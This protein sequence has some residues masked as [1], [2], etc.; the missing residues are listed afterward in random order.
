MSPLVETVSFVFGLVAFGYVAGWSGLLKPQT[1]DALSE[2]AVTVAVPLL[3]FRTMAG[4]AFD[5]NLPWALWTTYFSAVAVAWVA[6]HFTIVHFFGRDARAGVVAGLSTSFS[7]LV[8]LGIPFMLGVFGQQGF[9]VLSLI[10]SVHLPIM[11]GMSILLFALVGRKGGS[12]L[13]I[14][15]E[16]LTRL[17]SSPLII[18]IIAGLLW[19]FSGLEMPALGIRFVDALANVAGPVALFAMGLGLRRFGISGD[20]R[21][22]IVIAG[23]KLFLMP[24]VALG[25][26]L[27]IG[28]PVF[29]A[30]IAVVAAGLPSGV[31]PYLIASRFG[32]GQALASNAM[33]IATA[34]AVLST[35]FW[36]SVL[37]WTYQ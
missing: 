22:A 24:A 14:V 5:G 26:A 20:V 28:L 2:F 15:R 1:G 13:S 37:H 25:V 12:A 27:L 9:E 23:L 34:L 10:V 16:F 17:F 7:N 8:L 30:Q 31:N 6:G 35:A 18:G 3:L 29:S 19:R 33:T 21:P 4:A 11:M 32:T 36:L